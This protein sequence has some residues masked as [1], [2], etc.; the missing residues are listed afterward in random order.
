MNDIVDEVVSDIEPVG[1]L[2]D[3]LTDIV[4]STIA[5]LPA[6]I[7][8]AVVLTLTALIAWGVR[9]AIDRAFRNRKRVRNSLR[10]LFVNLAGILVWFAGLM[11]SAIILF[12]NLTPSSL[13]AGLGLGTVAIGF[14]FKDIFENFL[15]GIIILFREKMRMNDYIECEGL[16]G[17]IEEILIRET[18]IRRTDGQLVIVPNAMLFKNPLRIITDQDERRTTIIV[19]VAYGEDVDQARSVIRDAV[20]GC[21]SVIRPR[22]PI[23]IFA[24]EF[25]SSSIDFEVTWWTGSKPVDERK[26]RDEVVAAV[27]RALDDAGIEIPFPYRTLTFKEPLPLIRPANDEGRDDEERGGFEEA[28]E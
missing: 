25:N 18:H 12:P 3:Q 28:A 14:A 17:Q 23:Q 19:G 8:V 15:A 10:T 26:S 16:E 1:V 11:I 9:R 2:R 20:D 5:L 21:D 27:K 4:Q 7:V 13:V 6:L 22:R 24:R